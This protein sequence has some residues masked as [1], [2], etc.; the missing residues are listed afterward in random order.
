MGVDTEYAFPHGD[1]M[2]DDSESSG[3]C[4]LDMD[5]KDAHDPPYLLDARLIHWLPS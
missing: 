2:Y 1:D 4:I 5:T 3:S